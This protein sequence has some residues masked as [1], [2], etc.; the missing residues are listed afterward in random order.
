M[1]TS[2]TLIGKKGKII[3]DSTEIKIYLKEANP[4]ENLDK[5]WTV[6][7][8]TEF[9]IPVKFYLR[10]EEYSAQID[11]FIDCIVKKKQTE[12]NSFDQALYTDRVIEL[13]IADSK[14]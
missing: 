12:I 8:I 13:I 11:N 7:Y 4:K 9:A 3:C 1:S 6:K 14:S 10:G 5:G 2:L